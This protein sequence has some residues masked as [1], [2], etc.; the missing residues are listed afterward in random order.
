MPFLQQDVHDTRDVWQQ[1]QRQRED[2]EEEAD[3]DAGALRRWS[4]RLPQVE[5]RQVP[6]R[7]QVRQRDLRQRGEGGER[8]PQVRNVNHGR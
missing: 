6:H 3:V 7:R 8:Q 1:D 2:D 4:H 5:L